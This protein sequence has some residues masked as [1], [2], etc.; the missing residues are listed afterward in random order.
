MQSTWAIDMPVK[1]QPELSPELSKDDLL[2]LFANSAD[3]VAAERR[4]EESVQA[5]A[6]EFLRDVN[7]SSTIALGSLINCFNDSRLP[8]QPRP[9][10]DYLDYLADH[11]VRHS[12]RTASPRFIGHMTSALPWFLRPLAKL[13]A[14]MNQNVVKAETAKA[15]TPYERQALGMLH[16]L[17]F[18]LPDDF[19]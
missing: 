4:V 1:P 10:H 5:I 6:R 14:A 7:A 15:L 12:T 2:A 17:V 16:R 9:V 13:V 18:A 3:A 8:Q 19:Y 11:V